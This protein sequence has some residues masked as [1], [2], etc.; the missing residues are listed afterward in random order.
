VSDIILRAPL[1]DDAGPPRWLGVPDSSEDASLPLLLERGISISIA[2]TDGPSASADRCCDTDGGGG[3]ALTP[4]ELGRGRGGGFDVRAAGR[5]SGDRDVEGGLSESGGA[6]RTSG[7]DTGGRLGTIGSTEAT[8][9]VVGGRV[10]GPS[11]STE[12]C[13]DRAPDEDADALDDTDRGGS[14]ARA[15]P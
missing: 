15:S 6:G 11:R 13:P 1:L 14:G 5:A 12:T 9:G 4:G 8:R 10:S 2:S 3:G 7:T